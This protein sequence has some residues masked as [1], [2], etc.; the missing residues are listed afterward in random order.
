MRHSFVSVCLTGMLLFS[1]VSAAFA[2]SFSSGVS[3]Y[4]K[5]D[6]SRATGYLE[7]A[8]SVDPGNPKKLFY[9]GL[10]YA[11]GGK[12]EMARAAF[13]RVGQMLPPEDPLSV[14]ARNNMAVITQAHMTANGNTGKASQ[15]ASIAKSKN[16]N[17]YLAYAIPSGKII[18]WDT[19]KMPLKVYIGDGSKIQGWNPEMRD[20]VS[21]AMRSWQTA[22]NNQIR[23]VITKK[24][25]SAD[26]MVKWTR[27]FTHNKVGVNPFR[28]YGN[29]IVSSDLIIATYTSA[30]GPPMPMTE[31]GKTI[32]H[33]MGHAIGIQGHSPYPE[34]IMYWMVNPSQTAS[35]TSRDKNTIAMLYKLEADIKN[36]ANI[37]ATS[38]TARY[39]ELLEKAG[40]SMQA[41]KP[42]QALAIY[43]EAM[44][45][46]PN[47]PILYFNLGVAYG[48]MGQKSNSMMA[49]RKAI[50]I[51]SKF[52]DA[53]FNL[54]IGLLDEG[55]RLMANNQ[56]GAAQA[57]FREAVTL[58]EDVQRSP[59]PP[60]NMGKILDFARKSLS[61][62][63]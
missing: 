19:A 26:I 27:N 42:Q 47:D 16:K 34:D 15:V 8:V 54:G 20:L 38:Q 55:S 1:G 30:D 52:Y 29:T 17:N 59:K 49:Y 63:S 40:R 45:L 53:K 11:Q 32:I 4:Q 35:L 21:N 60:P 5:G 18:H 43:Q 36:D 22:T 10:C 14:K 48:D 50:A 6:F 37:G 12:Y 28:S 56:A 58:L 61:Y 25:E 46:N 24:P 44:K 33:E 39:F 13:E 9:L 51:N 2:D 41:K 31:L 3:A 23:F 7:Q 62:S 57:S